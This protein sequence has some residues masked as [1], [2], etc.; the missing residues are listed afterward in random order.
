MTS[1]HKHQAQRTGMPS[2]D[3]PPKD[4]WNEL[5]QQKEQVWSGKVNASLAQVLENYPPTT[6]LDLGCGEG[7]DVL[8]LAQAGWQA[9]G[10]DISDTA[11]ERA[12]TAA[13]QQG[14]QDRARF[15]CQDLNNWDPTE[16]FDL[17]IS[18]FLQSPVELEREKILAAALTR[19]NP[20]GRLIAIAHAG[21]PHWVET[22]PDFHRF[23]DPQ[24]EAAHLAPQGSPYLVERADIID[25]EIQDPD[26]KPATIKD[27]L[28]IIQRQA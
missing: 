28:L 25:R 19:L 22:D 24:A 18:S 27:S 7:A 6:V 3:L 17:I 10:I 5:Y 8:W 11:I 1:Q 13:T 15:I 12:R 26:G 21:L 2:F 16:T 4:F 23:P 9:T 14:L 20:G